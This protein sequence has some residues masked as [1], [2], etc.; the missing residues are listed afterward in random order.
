MQWSCIYEYICI[1]S[2]VIS[3]GMITDVLGGILTSIPGIPCDNVSQGR[4]ALRAYVI[5]PPSPTPT[6][7]LLSFPAVHRAEGVWKYE[8]EG[9]GECGKSCVTWH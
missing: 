7:I 2:R 9:G 4:S 5:S 3:P 1:D 6:V 8:N